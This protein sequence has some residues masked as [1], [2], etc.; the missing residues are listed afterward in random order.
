MLSPEELEQLYNTIKNN[1]ALPVWFVV[2]YKSIISRNITIEDWNKMMD[3]LKVLAKDNNTLLELTNALSEQ[4]ISEATEILAETAARI[5]KDNELLNKITANEV[6]IL[7]LQNAINVLTTAP[8][9]SERI[10]VPEVRFSQSANNYKITGADGVNIYD[11]SGLIWKFK[12]G[13]L[14]V[15]AITV[16]DY[17]PINDK[18]YL[19][20]S[21]RYLDA[22][23]VSKIFSSEGNFSTSLKINNKDVATKEYVEGSIWDVLLDSSTYVMTFKDKNG[24]TIKQFDLPIESFFKNVTYDSTNKKLIFTLQN[25]D[26]VEV[27]IGDLVDTYTGDGVYVD[28]NNNTITLTSAFLQ[29]ISTIQS[30]QTAQAQRMTQLETAVQNVA[31]TCV[32]TSMASYTYT[33]EDNKAVTFT[34]GAVQDIQLT[35]PSTVTHGFKSYLSLNSR[36]DGIFNMSRI[37]FF[38]NTNLNIICLINSVPTEITMDTWIPLWDGKWNILIECNGNNI[39]IREEYIEE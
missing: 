21:D 32:T 38:N 39:Y 37:K 34:A 30:T 33:L 36:Y 23:Y 25:G 15:S 8:V 14:L 7:N 17:D 31:T 26:V 1:Q 9:I 16:I 11:N 10:T 12:N 5:A 3:Y 2:N 24:N 27:P 4:S 22:I 19:G 29:T 13:K 20:T 18:F 6:A 35:I 28:V